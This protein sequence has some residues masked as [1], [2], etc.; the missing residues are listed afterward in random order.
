MLDCVMMLAPNGCHWTS[1]RSCDSDVVQG[2]WTDHLWVGANVEQ[3]PTVGA[4]TALL[5]I[6][7]GDICKLVFRALWRETMGVRKTPG[8]FF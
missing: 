2:R 5:S 4:S 6:S 8:C 1:T 7:L 3:G